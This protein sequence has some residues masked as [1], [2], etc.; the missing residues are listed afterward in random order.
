[1]KPSRQKSHFSIGMLV[2]ALAL[3]LAACGST[4]TAPPPTAAPQVTLTI[5]GS[6][7]TSSILSGVKPAF[8]AAAPGYTLDVLPGTGTSEGVQGVIQGVFD[9]AAMARPSK[10]EEAAQGIEYVEFGQSGVA[11]FT[12]GVDVASLTTAQVQ[13]LF[14]GEIANWS[15]VGRPDLPVILYVRDE[16]DSST[17]VLRQVVFGDAPF[18]ETVQVLTSQT[19]M[20]VAVAGTPGSVGFGSWPAA[21]VT[22]AD[23]RAIALDGIAPGDPAYP[24]VSPVGIGYLSARKADVQPLI[25]WLLSEQ[26]QTALGE[27]DVIAAS[28]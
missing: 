20:Q 9:V 5:S 15:E 6:G 12:H 25:D 8:E 26:G 10:E 7:T 2:A 23:V 13:A 18:P 21:L 24:M 4:E 27:F 19:D 28:Q 3:T 22:E 11:I 14:S 1:M 17:K 16:G